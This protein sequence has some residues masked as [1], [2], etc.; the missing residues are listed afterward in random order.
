MVSNE[1]LRMVLVE[2]VIFETTASLNMVYCAQFFTCV[3]MLI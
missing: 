3:P 1:L 2:G